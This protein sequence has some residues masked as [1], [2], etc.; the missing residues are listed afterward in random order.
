MTILLSFLLVAATLAVNLSI[1]RAA[2][3]KA[4]LKENENGTS[5]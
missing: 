5:D 2:E 1:W 3:T 4:N